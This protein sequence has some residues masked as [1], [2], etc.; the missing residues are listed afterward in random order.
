MLGRKEPSGSAVFSQKDFKPARTVSGETSGG[1]TGGCSAHAHKHS[2]AAQPTH[3][4]GLLAVR[5]IRG[6]WL[7]AFAGCVQGAARRESRM[8]ASSRG[9]SHGQNHRN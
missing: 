4:E 1:G 3:M 7:V 8:A 6:S 5:R 2:D 9:Q